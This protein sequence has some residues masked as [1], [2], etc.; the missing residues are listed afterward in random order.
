MDVMFKWKERKRMFTNSFTFIL[1][2]PRTTRFA[3]S[4]TSPWITHFRE[5]E[6]THT[7]NPSPL[8]AYH[9]RLVL[10]AAFPSTCGGVDKQLQTRPRTYAKYRQYGYGLVNKTCRCRRCCRRCRLPATSRPPQPPSA[11]NAASLALVKRYE[12]HFMC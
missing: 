10:H 11:L 12:C 9:A 1:V 5:S 4:C 3:P 8:L 6:N 2:Q 7:A